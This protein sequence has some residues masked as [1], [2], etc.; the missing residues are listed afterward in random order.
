VFVQV[1]QGQFGVVAD[2]RQGSEHRLQV[3]RRAGFDLDPGGQCGRQREG[4]SQIVVGVGARLSGLAEPAGRSGEPRPGLVEG[5][6]GNVAD[7][8]GVGGVVGV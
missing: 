7:G 8:A 4:G 1:E 5:D 6:R 2:R 3:S